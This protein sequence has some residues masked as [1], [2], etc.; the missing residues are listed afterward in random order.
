M[1]LKIS[2][3]KFIIPRK[4]FDESMESYSGRLLWSEKIKEPRRWE[5]RYWVVTSMMLSHSQSWAN[6]YEVVPLAEWV[7]DVYVFGCFDDKWIMERDRSGLF[8][9]GVLVQTEESSEQFVLSTKVHWVREKQPKAKK[10]G[11]DS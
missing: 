7:G 3:P 5:D 6:L 10:Q 4:M 1:P 2:T 9:H 8:W 11:Q